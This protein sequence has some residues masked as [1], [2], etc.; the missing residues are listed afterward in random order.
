MI[1]V[2]VAQGGCE[3]DSLAGDALPRGYCYLV[4]DDLSTPIEPALLWLSNTYPPVQKLWRPATVEASAYDLCDWWRFLEH[5]KRPWDEAGSDDLAAYRDGLLVAISPN[6]QRPFSAKTIARR[7]RTVGAFYDWALDRGYVAGEPISPK[8]IVLTK[9]PIDRDALGHISTGTGSQ[10]RKVHVLAPR[11]STDSDERV[12]P[13]TSAEWRN[14]AKMLG[15]LPSESFGGAEGLCRD[16]LAAE[17]SLWTG[18][19]ADEVA[20]LTI[21]QV[22]ELDRACG[23]ESI[24][25]VD[26]TRTK[27]L[28]RRKVLVPRHL[29]DELISYMDTERAEAVKTGR[30][31]RRGREPAALFVNGLAARHHAGLPIQSYTLSSAFSRSVS[32]AGYLRSVEK[33]DLATGKTY[34]DHLPGHCFHDLRHT[35]AVWLYHAEIAAGNPEPWKNLQARLGHKSLNTTRD[36]Y[37]RTVDIFRSSVNDNVYQYLRRSFGA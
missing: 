6:Q 12:C 28:R 7:V 10:L 8:T 3:I 20:G 35:F 17:V 32:A 9:R 14:V 25:A 31:F 24:A 4:D 18:M 5:I 1:T 15:P 33:V 23:P 30:R 29:I 16:R 26:L 2:A 34:I 21:H 11:V 19:R 13:L 27:G 36:I 22:L 37:L